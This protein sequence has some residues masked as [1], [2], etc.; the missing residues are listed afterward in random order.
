MTQHYD[1]HHCPHYLAT[2]ALRLTITPGDQGMPQEKL[3]E[4]RE[5]LAQGV[6]EAI[7]KGL[8]FDGEQP[9]LA[10]ISVDITTARTTQLQKATQ[11]PI[12]LEIWK[13]H[14]EKEGYLMY[15]RSKTYGEVREELRERL[16]AEGMIDEGLSTTVKPEIRVPHPYRWIACF[17]VTGTNE[18]HY[19]HVEIF[20]SGVDEHHKHTGELVFLTKT[21]GGFERAQAIASACARHLGA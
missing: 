7:P 20:Q 3:Y 8:T 10:G 21:F 5:A 4:F 2:V 17:A 11:E 1:A 14:P 6:Y 13:K 16:E 19:V 12:Q 15:D 18:G 9:S